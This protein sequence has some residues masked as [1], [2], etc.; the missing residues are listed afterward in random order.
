MMQNKPLTKGQTSFFKPINLQKNNEQIS[1]FFFGSM[2]KSKDKWDILSDLHTWGLRPH[3]VQG[4]NR[5]E[6][7]GATAPMVGRSCP[8]WLE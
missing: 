6:N 5:E 8:P 3:Y 1:R 7:L 2:T 4:R